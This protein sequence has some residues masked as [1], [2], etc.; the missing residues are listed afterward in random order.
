EQ[1][2]TVNPDSIYETRLPVHEQVT[3]GDRASRK[4]IDYIMYTHYSAE[5]KLSNQE[6]AEDF[7]KSNF[8]VLST[9]PD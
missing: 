2:S 6:R 1:S 5:T 4:T 3:L 8:R 7:R 9:T